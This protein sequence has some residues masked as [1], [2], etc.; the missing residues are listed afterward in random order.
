[1]E[2]KFEHAGELHV[3]T[4]VG[5]VTLGFLCLIFQKTKNFPLYFSFKFKQILTHGIQSYKHYVQLKLGC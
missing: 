4:K 1:M 2:K 3:N 5:E